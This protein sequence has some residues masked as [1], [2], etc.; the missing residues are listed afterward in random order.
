MTHN[1][2]HISI[3]RNMA[4]SWLQLLQNLPNSNAIMLLRLESS[5][6]SVLSHQS[7]KIDEDSK[8]FELF[9]LSVATLATFRKKI[10]LIDELFREKISIKTAT[11]IYGCTVNWLILACK[12]DSKQTTSIAVFD[13]LP[14][15]QMV[16]RMLQHFE[17]AHIWNS[18]QWFIKSVFI[19]TRAFNLREMDV[20]DW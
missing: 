16:F 2:G 1:L 3:S 18:K 7:E 5:M 8:L 20:L 6:E 9:P 10:Q 17:D 11:K 13:R 4:K 15:L 14:Q 19:S 12:F